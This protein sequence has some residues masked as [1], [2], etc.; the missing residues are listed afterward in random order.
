MTYPAKALSK[1][2]GHGFLR[3][4]FENDQTLLKVLLA[5]ASESVTHAGTAGAVAES[6]WIRL[7]RRY[8]PERYSI[9]T[10]I[11]IDSLG[12]TSD[13]IDVVIFDKHYTPTLL[14]QENHRYVPVE[15]VYAVLEV[16]PELNAN[17]LEYAGRKARSVRRLTR[18][19]I[20]ITHAGGAFPPRPLF[21]IV[22]GLVALRGGWKG[23]LGQPFKNAH[24]KLTGQRVVNCGCALESGSFDD[25]DTT[26]S[27]RS[28][29]A[30]LSHFLFRLL[31][32]LQ[33]MGTAPAV[34]W[35]A[36]AKCFSHAP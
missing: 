30:V 7:L 6:H 34:D 27:V 15:A 23:G 4:A 26:L 36:Y 5:Q 29:A 33:S 31:K 24:K 3:R 19:S 12:R 9:D 16:K 11:V 10:A 21:G 8:L 1:K 35:D 25:F 20:A 13:Q 17:Y 14:D 22:A 2:D 32:K 18:T 28:S